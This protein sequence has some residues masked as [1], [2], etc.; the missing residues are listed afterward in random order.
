M[1]QSVTDPSCDI[2][3]AA[4]YGVGVA[5]K[6]GGPSYSQFCIGKVFLLTKLPFLIY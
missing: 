2:R 1:G 4:A 3:Q 5:A 6:F